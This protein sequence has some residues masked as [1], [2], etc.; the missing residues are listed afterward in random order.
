M[1]NINN[2]VQ[3]VALDNHIKQLLLYLN[4]LKR[5]SVMIH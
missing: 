4:L 5:L 3:T 1:S 2:I